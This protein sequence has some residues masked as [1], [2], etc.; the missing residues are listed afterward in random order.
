LERT[1]YNPVFDIKFEDFMDMI[2]EVGEV[3]IYARRG[4][5]LP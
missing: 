4:K 2:Y 3:R 5:A 1:T